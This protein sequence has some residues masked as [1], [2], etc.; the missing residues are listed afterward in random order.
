MPI[1]A[2]RLA[3]TADHADHAPPP[4]CSAAPLTWSSTLANF[5]QT[6]SNTCVMQHSGGPYG[7]NLAMG[8]R[9]S[10]T[11]GVKLWTDEESS[12]GGGYSPSSGHYSQVVWKGTKRVGCATRAC[13]GSNLITCEYEPRGNIIGQFG[14]NVN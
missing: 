14:Q 2:P 5:A 4:D 3:G 13:G 12:Y 9:L 8:T 11:R 7:E 1:L 6:V 10:C